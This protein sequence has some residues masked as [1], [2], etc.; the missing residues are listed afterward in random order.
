MSGQRSGREPA[1]NADEKRKDQRENDCQ[2]AELQR[3]RQGIADQGE[4][5]GAF[6]TGGIA[7]TGAA[8]RGAAC[9]AYEGVP[10]ITPD[11][12]AHVAAELHQ[13]RVAQAHVLG[14]LLDQRLGRHAAGI[15]RTGSPGTT[16]SSVKISSVTRKT[17]NDAL[18]QPANQ[19]TKNEHFIS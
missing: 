9:R 3:H 14:D 2:A 19:K 18:R 7:E 10:E 1:G 15:N 6:A 5:L 4:H 13:D 8:G 12:A 16:R 17:I 11:D